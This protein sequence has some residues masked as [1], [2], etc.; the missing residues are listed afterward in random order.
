MSYQEKLQPLPQPQSAL[1]IEPLLDSSGHA[2]KGF[3]S[4]SRP[5]I[6][7]VKSLGYKFAGRAYNTASLH[8]DQFKSTHPRLFKFKRLIAS[9]IRVIESVAL[10]A[11]LY[12]AAFSVSTSFTPPESLAPKNSS[13]WTKAAVFKS[14][15]NVPPSLQK[16]WVEL[17]NFKF[18][19]P[20][21]IYAAWHRT[22]Y[23]RVSVSQGNSYHALSDT[24]KTDFPLNKF[25]REID[26]DKNT[27]K[28]FNKNSAR[29]TQIYCL[30]INGCRLDLQDLDTVPNIF[31]LIQYDNS[32]VTLRLPADSGYEID[33]SSFSLESQKTL[34]SSPTKELVVNPATSKEGVLYRFKII[35]KQTQMGKIIDYNVINKASTGYSFLSIFPVAMLSLLSFGVLTGLGALKKSKE[36]KYRDTFLTQML[37]SY[38]P[39]ERETHT[40]TVNEFIAALSSFITEKT[41][42]QLRKS[43]KENINEILH[44]LKNAIEHCSPAPTPAQYTEFYKAC[45]E[46]MLKLKTTTSE[47]EVKALGTRFEHEFD[48]YIV[49]AIL[50]ISQTPY[51][52]IE[53]FKEAVSL[54]KEHKLSYN[55]VVGWTNSS[56]PPSL[57]MPNIEKIN[58]FA[59]L[60]LFHKNFKNYNSNSSDTKLLHLSK[61]EYLIQMAD[62]P[63]KENNYPLIPLLR[64]VHPSPEKINLISKLLERYSSQDL[65]TL[66][67]LNLPKE[68]FLNDDAL[69]LV[70]AAL[71]KRMLEEAIPT[72]RRFLEMSTPRSKSKI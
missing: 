60:E 58:E 22:P 21:L 68:S 45:I 63:V 6:S 24:V 34:N 50:N 25:G 44:N 42:G 7:S 61:I 19:A 54:I 4:S 59:W 28:T 47:D 13:P 14:N 55:A 9:N 69:L 67:N 30:D 64:E 32:P 66:I 5:S 31:T 46:M 52:S 65:K 62:F 49:K 27:P 8:Y 12:T 10:G 20:A 11:A 48:D 37:R 57:D 43:S 23:Y 29:V 40:K 71:E 15:S 16:I 70:S 36:K 72:E 17:L 2:P 51:F 41:D 56:L 26:S 38:L 53:D 33:K 3:P 18:N 35:N 39:P 1:T